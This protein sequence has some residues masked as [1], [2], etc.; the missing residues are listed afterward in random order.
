MK[1]LVNPSVTREVIDRFSFHFKKQLGQNFL[2]DANILGKIV[3]AADLSKEDGAL[4]IGP[5]IGTL[6]QALAEHAGVVVAVEKDDRLI[7][8][9]AE[10]LRECPNVWV[11]HA[12]VLET[13]LHRLFADRFAGRKVSVVA[14][15][16]YYVTTPIVMKLLEE[17]LPLNSV[18][19]MVQREVAERMAAS[20]GGKDYGALSI[21]VQYFTEPQIVCRVPKTAFMPQPNVESIVIKLK[22]REQAA[23]AVQDEKIFFKLVRAGFAQRRKTLLNNLQYNLHLPGGKAMVLQLLEGSGVDPNRRAETLSIEEFARLADGIA[24]FL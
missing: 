16:P 24:R 17:R 20:P 7:P 8:I 5:G 12:D 19:V 23:V 13:D 1:R 18:V 9:L 10:T 14:N 21:A 4:E 11:H 2:I 22:I 6:T 15:L 3:E